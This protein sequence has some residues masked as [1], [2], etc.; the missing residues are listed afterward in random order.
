METKDIF[1][2]E[3]KYLMSI[4]EPAQLRDVL[5]KEFMERSI[6]FTGRSNV[7]KSSLINKLFGKT[8]ARVSRTPGR[9]QAVNIFEFEIQGHEDKGPFY[10][11][12]LPGYGHAK[13][14]KVMQRNWGELLGLFFELLP[15][16]RLIINIQ[17]ARHPGQKSDLHF[18]E[19]ASP[20]ANQTFLLFNKMDKLKNQKDRN[21]L[22]NQKEALFKKYKAAKQIHFVSAERGDGIEALVIALRSFLLTEE[23]PRS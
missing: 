19:F 10:F 8:I 20:K 18:W 12:D 17:D 4:T 5:T 7:G 21:Q 11:F 2:S 14:P 16:N 1:K 15:P 6:C 23:P 22:N 13:V 9:T 3:T